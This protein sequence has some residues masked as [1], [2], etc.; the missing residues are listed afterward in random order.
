M[1]A[2][3]AAI[4][5][6]VGAEAR[7]SV[8]A[9]WGSKNRTAILGLSDGREVV[10]QRYRDRE[11]A[12]LRVRAAEQLSD[13]FSHLS[14]RIPHVIAH[15]L[16]A[17]P[18]WAVF[19]RAPGDVGYIAAGDDLSAP[20]FPAMAQSMG[21]I[22][23]VLRQ[24]EADRFDLPNLWAR[25]THLQSAAVG[26]LE[27]L[28]PHLSADAV[29]TTRILLDRLPELFTGRQPVVAHGDFGP[30]NVLII[31]HRV[32]AVLDLEDVRLADPLL[33]V[34]WWAWLVRAHTP[35]AFQRAWKPFI[36]AA[37]V[38]LGD[39]FLESRLLTLI[40]TR[41]LETADTFRKTQPEKHPSWGERLEHVLTWRPT[42]L[43][44]HQ[45][46]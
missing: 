20:T 32:T 45:A 19:E 30:Q 39:P 31:G 42:D 29:A 12:V 5:Q 17:R 46:D 3:L 8:D 28:V 38:D 7:S 16:R 44:P 22:L 14:A 41:L 21:E 43:Q 36:T 6:T 25:P 33:D 23:Q 26:W 15:D 27:Q 18:P 9:P 40:A 24:L 11:T 13:A 35:H 2:E 10:V 34:A 1:D 4:A 37:G